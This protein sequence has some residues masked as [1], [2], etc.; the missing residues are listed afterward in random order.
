MVRA[1]CICRNIFK[2]EKQ[3]RDLT[4]IKILETKYLGIFF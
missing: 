4:D 3:V 1:T 2:R